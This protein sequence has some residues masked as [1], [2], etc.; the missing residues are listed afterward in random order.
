LAALK[1]PAKAGT[2]NALSRRATIDVIVLSIMADM[3]EK[4]WLYSSAAL[5]LHG[6]M[7]SRLQAEPLKFLYVK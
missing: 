3:Q 6:V 5:S 1:I 7:E 4:P 2:Q